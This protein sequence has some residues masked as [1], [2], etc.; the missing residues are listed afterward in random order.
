[1]AQLRE[2]ALLPRLCRYRSAPG[3][4]GGHSLLTFL[5]SSDIAEWA[6]S[7]FPRDPTSADPAAT[8]FW[9]LREDDEVVAAGNMT[10]WRG[11]PADVGVLTHPMRRGQGLARRLVGAMVAVTGSARRTS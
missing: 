6:E 10:E 3:G 7:G 8:R 11:L 4:R 5:L 1:M 9:V 2:R